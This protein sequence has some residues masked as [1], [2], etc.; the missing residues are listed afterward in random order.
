MRYSFLLQRKIERGKNF[1]ETSR[2]STSI[3]NNENEKS[4]T[5]MENPYF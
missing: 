4:C 1:H 2:Y 5:I 3:E